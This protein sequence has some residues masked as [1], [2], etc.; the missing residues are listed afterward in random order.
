MFQVFPSHVD[1]PIFESTGQVLRENRKYGD[2]IL[3]LD[4]DSIRRC[5]KSFDASIVLKKGE[6]LSKLM[7]SP[8]RP[9]TG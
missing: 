5:C 9:S 6:Y 7:I 4:T 1:L 2:R 8:A 3:S